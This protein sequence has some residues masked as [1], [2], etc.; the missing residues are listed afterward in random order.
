MI[1]RFI[2]LTFIPISLIGVS[3]AAAS[4]SDLDNTKPTNPI[5]PETEP[6]TEQSDKEGI[7]PNDLV[8]SEAETSQDNNA[9]LS[10]N[11]PN[12]KVRPFINCDLN[13]SIKCM[14]T[15]MSDTILGGKNQDQIVGLG[16]SDWINGSG[17]ND[18]IFG[19]GSNDIIYGDKGNDVLMGNDGADKIF[20]GYGFDQIQ[21]GLGDDV[22]YQSHD[23]Y[24]DI[25][26][27]GPGNDEVRATAPMEVDSLQNCEKIKPW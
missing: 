18:L 13:P 11:D 25:I 12:L 16:G 15:E 7:A 17:G 1:L 10:E 22:I 8:K 24:P 27:C 6:P 9:I 2:L 3:T 26:D 5:G 4:V 20:G 23:G 14:G 19:Y 21:G